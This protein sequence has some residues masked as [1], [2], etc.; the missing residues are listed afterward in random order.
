MNNKRLYDLAYQ[1]KSTK[2]WKRLYDSE[3]FA[4]RLADGSLGYISIMGDLGEH[5]AISLYI[6]RSGL[7]SFR[8]MYELESAVSEMARYELMLSQDCIQ[9]S[10][11]NRDEL[12]PLEIE[13]V[14]AYAKAKGITLKGPKA[15][16]Q[17]K[18][19]K[20]NHY[21]WFLKTEEDRLS[22]SE[23]IEAAIALS[24]RLKTID[25]KSLGFK[26]GAPYDRDIPL[27]EKKN[28]SYEFGA[29]SLPPRQEPD[30][31]SPVLRDELLAARL[32]KK[33]D[34]KASWSCEV[35]LIPKPVSDETAEG[36][37][38]VSMPE[39]AP[40][41]PF[42][43]LVVD[44]DAEMIITTDIIA[45]YDNDC[46]RLLSYFAESMETE[47]VPREFVVR[48][49]RTKTLLSRFSEQIGVKL[50]FREDIPILDSI[51]EDMFESFGGGKP[52]HNDETED[53][54]G[55]F[56]FLMQ[57]S[58]K[59][60]VTLPR[61]LQLQVLEMDEAGLLKPDMSARIRRLFKP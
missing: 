38:V 32:K 39:A 17:F 21:P 37:G 15:F 3:L 10:F 56:D 44:M 30:Y 24:E 49:R 59:E 55:L 53:I 16:A 26:T 12:H 23:A 58:D 42:T 50:T 2:L 29:I 34:R 52:P 57:L 13:E 51:E 6:G 25:K 8:N 36:G 46:D 45:D 7:D 11:E 35:I 48:D 41:F 14:K 18:V 27:I 9:C 31:P 43:L 4:I 40:V 19:Y 47:G 33:K 61:E 5:I 54:N 1:Y 20:P 22:V 28:G 60:L